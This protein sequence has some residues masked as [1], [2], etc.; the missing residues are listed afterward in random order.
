MSAEKLPV[1]YWCPECHKVFEGVPR[2]EIAW[3]V[4]HVEDF[5]GL[6]VTFLQPDPTLVNVCEDGCKFGITP[7]YVHA[8]KCKV[9][10]RIYDDRQDAQECCQ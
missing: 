2:Q 4:S 1:A 10:S 8:W 6:D 7:T 3:Y 9:C 5:H